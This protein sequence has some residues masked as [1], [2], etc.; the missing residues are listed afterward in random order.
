[1]DGDRAVQ[2]I[3]DAGCVVLWVGATLAVVG[4]LWLPSLA[5]PGAIVFLI[6]AGFVAI[7]VLLVVGLV[8]FGLWRGDF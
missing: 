1:M 6:G 2:K 3:A 8:L 7:A 4:I 5:V